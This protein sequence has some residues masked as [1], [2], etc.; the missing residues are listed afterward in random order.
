MISFK[1]N[2]A[3]DTGE[4]WW[5]QGMVVFGEVT[6]WIVVP[7]VGSLYL[8]QYLDGVYGTR[9]VF[10]LV[11]TAVAFI[12]SCAGIGIVAVKYIKQIE[13]SNANNQKNSDGSKRNNKSTD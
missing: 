11:L 8:G 6:G 4:A 9:N 1:K 2:N 3:A 13:R 7:I 12:I 5:R 10:F